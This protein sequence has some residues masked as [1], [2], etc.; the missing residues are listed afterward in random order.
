MG[1]DGM[2]LRDGLDRR[3][4]RHQ[5]NNNYNKNNNTNNLVYMQIICKGF[6]ATQ[7]VSCLRFKTFNKTKEKN[8]KIENDTSTN[9]PLCSRKKHLS[10]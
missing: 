6:L 7:E 1:W 5:N 3:T 8:M 2:A 10:Y 9:L 4:D